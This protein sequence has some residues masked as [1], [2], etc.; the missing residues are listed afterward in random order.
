[1]QAI[2]QAL[3]RRYHRLV[4]DAPIYLILQVILCLLS[5]ASYIGYIMNKEKTHINIVI[6]GH[7]DSG[8]STT[9]GHFIYKSGGVDRKTI[10]KYEKEAQKV[11][12][13]SCIVPLYGNTNC[14]KLW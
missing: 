12:S 7:V 9:A 3:G 8:K 4:R 10:E 1:M 6:I 5:C 13:L 14:F 11:G 2:K